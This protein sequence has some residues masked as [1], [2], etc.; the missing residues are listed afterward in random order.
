MTYGQA[1]QFVLGRS[2]DLNTQEYKIR[3]NAVWLLVLAGEFV[4]HV[5]SSADGIIPAK[6]VIHHQMA[7]ILDGNTGEIIGR[8]MISPQ[9]V[10][11]V[12]SL[13]V[14][15]ESSDALPALPTKGPIST[16]VPY[17]TLSP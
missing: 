12:S 16:E 9:K 10:L 2:I 4:E 6:D 14:L 5:P 1:V 8:V 11:L 15:I 7:I 3:N 17:P 13:P